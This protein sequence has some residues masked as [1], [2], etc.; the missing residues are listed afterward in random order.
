[1]SFYTNHLLSSQNVGQ[2]QNTRL[3]T[4][5]MAGWYGSYETVVRSP[6]LI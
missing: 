2:E 6:S 4:G 5:A 3:P 1:M